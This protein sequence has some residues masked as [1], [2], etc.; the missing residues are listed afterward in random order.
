MSTLAQRRNVGLRGDVTSPIQE[1]V[2]VLF[3]T[4]HHLRSRSLKGGIRPHDSHHARRADRF[5]YIALNALTGCEEH[6]TAR[7]AD[8]V[9]L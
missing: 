4:L 3:D 7:P 6:V 8:L 5:V 2:T 1:P 9:V